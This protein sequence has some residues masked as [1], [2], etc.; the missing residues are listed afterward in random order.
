MTS[1]VT[2]DG[3]DWLIKAGLLEP[4]PTHLWN[5]QTMGPMPPYKLEL[6]STPPASSDDMAAALRAQYPQ[7]TY[8]LF[9]HGTRHWLER[10]A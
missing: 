8:R 4:R 5:S 1:R 7:S 3:S 9:K 6:G 10:R 2:T